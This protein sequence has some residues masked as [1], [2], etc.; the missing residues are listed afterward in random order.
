[1]FYAR[2]DVTA[3]KDRLLSMPAAVRWFGITAKNLSLYC[4]LS[5]VML[6][7]A[8]GISIYTFKQKQA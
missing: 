1:M 5:V 2:D 7:D 8:N 3:D 6:K 4:R